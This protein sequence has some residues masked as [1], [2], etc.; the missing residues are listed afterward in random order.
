MP[1]LGVHLARRVAKQTALVGKFAHVRMVVLAAPAVW[2][3]SAA[4]VA[5]PDSTQGQTLEAPAAL[6]ERLDLG[7][8]QVHPGPGGAQVLVDHRSVRRVRRAAGCWEPS[9]KALAVARTGLSRA[10]PF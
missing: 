8:P 3:D 1:V 2:V 10:V 9:A 4:L 6:G 5:R 7:G